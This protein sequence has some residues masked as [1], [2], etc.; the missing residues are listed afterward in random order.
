MNEDKMEYKIQARRES[1]YQFTIDFGLENVPSLLVDEDPPLG[2]ADGPDPSR[3]LAAAVSH[4]MAS[5]FL[6]CMGKSKATVGKVEIQ[7]NIK[8]GRNENGRLRIMGI[9][10]SIDAE[11]SEDER[12]KLERCRGIFENFCTVSQSIRGGIPIDVK[13][14]EKTNYPERGT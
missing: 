13:I 14:A 10:L 7:T 11:I 9:E 12:S 6:F 2:N 4:C 1:D 5:S 8:F 3:L